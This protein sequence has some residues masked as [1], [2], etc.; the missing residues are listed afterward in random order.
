MVMLR[1][2]ARQWVSLLIRGC[3]KIGSHAGGIVGSG[4]VVWLGWGHCVR[5]G[6][7]D[8]GLGGWDWPVWWS[9]GV[10]V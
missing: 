5:I 3:V 8:G 9:P 7:H 6:S 1:V 2:G 4:L 10:V